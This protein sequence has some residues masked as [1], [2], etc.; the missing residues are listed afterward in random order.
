MKGHAFS[1]GELLQPLVVGVVVFGL[2]NLQ[3]WRDGLFGRAGVLE[4]V[5]FEQVAFGLQVFFDLFLLGEVVHSL[6][7][8]PVEVLGF[9]H[10]HFFY[11]LLLIQKADQPQQE[12]LAVRHDALDV[13]TAH[14]DFN[15]GP[16][17]AVS[18]QPL[19]E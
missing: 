16:I 19:E 1:L 3:R 4:V 13:S 10:R 12:L 17:L 8:H 11:F 2:L 5:D 15:P 9:L 18:P 6:A 14:Q 7:Q